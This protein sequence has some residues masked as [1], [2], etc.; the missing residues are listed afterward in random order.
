MPGVNALILGSEYLNL[1]GLFTKAGL[2]MNRVMPFSIPI[3]SDQTLRIPQKLGL[4]FL[5]ASGKPEIRES[6]TVIGPDL[7]H[8]DRPIKV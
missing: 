5:K 1:S 6:K 8:G 7:V 2:T 4:P 3:I